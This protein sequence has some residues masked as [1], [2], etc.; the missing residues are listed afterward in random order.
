MLVS[1]LFLLHLPMTG[2]LGGSNEPEIQGKYNWMTCN[3]VRSC[4][5]LRNKEKNEYKNTRFAS[6]RQRCLRPYNL[7]NLS[8]E[9]KHRS[10]TDDHFFVFTFIHSRI[11]YILFCCILYIV[12]C[13]SIERTWFHIISQLGLIFS[14]IPG[15]WFKMLLEMV[16]CELKEYVFSGHVLIFIYIIRNKCFTSFIINLYIIVPKA[17]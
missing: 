6:V 14:F 11:S 16:K 8:R 17:A 2:A 7:D 10:L 1:C 4:W 15:F 13:M 5:W 12:Y 3:D 9:Q